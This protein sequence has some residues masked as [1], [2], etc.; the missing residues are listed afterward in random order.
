MPSL[1]RR[2]RMKKGEDVAAPDLGLGA[3]MEAEAGIG[4]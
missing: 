1:A 4:R 3:E 2:S